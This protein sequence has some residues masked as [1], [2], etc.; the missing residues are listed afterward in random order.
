MKNL[1]NYFSSKLNKYNR[2]CLRVSFFDIEIKEG[3]NLISFPLII[4]Y[5]PTQLKSENP[6]ISSIKEYNNNN[7]VEATTL[8]NNKGYF[9]EASSDFI[10]T[11]TG[12]E[13]RNTQNVL[14]S[15]GMNLI[16]ISSLSNIIL[17][18]LPDEIIEVAKRKD[19]GV[20]DISTKYDSNWFNSFELEPGKGYWFK[21]EIDEV[22]WSY[23]P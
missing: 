18:D 16:G 2:D 11:T 22:T 8:E 12:D 6:N 14:L 17:N 10:L 19:D 7:F 13:P 21:I 15:Q 5:T 4:N 20:Y 9:I 3:Q 1:H 23:S